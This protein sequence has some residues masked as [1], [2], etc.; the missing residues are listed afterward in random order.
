M[1]RIIWKTRFYE[2]LSYNLSSYRFNIC[3]IKYFYSVLN[4]FKNEICWKHG[5]VDLNYSKHE[6]HI[7]ISLQFVEIPGEERSNQTYLSDILFENYIIKKI[8][9]IIR[10]FSYYMRSLFSLSIT[11]T[12]FHFARP[13]FEK[14]LFSM[15]S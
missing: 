11:L 5:E 4:I 3:L 10:I 8:I 12:S 15:I 1:S 9:Y 2:F 6:K 14:R 13:K 7:C